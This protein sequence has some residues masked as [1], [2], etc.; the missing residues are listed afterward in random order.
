[1]ELL[2]YS[3]DNEL[4]LLDNKLKYA[5]KIQNLK[6]RKLKL[7]LNSSIITY[8]NHLYNF[9]IAWLYPTT[10]TTFTHFFANVVSIFLL[11]LEV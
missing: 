1:M 9:Q 8:L 2:I 6:Y 10:T 7:R 11:Y 5:G 4:Y 3:L